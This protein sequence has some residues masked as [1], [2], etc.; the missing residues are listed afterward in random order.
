MA[1]NRAHLVA[2]R[3]GSR[4][5][6]TTLVRRLE[7]IAE[8]EDMD[9]VHKL[10]ELETKHQALRERYRTIEDLDQ[11][12][13]ALTQVEALEVEMTAVDVV[14]TVYQDALSLYQ[15]NINL[16][17]RAVEA[18]KLIFDQLHLLNHN[19]YK[20][21]CSQQTENNAPAFRWRNSTLAALLASVS[22]RN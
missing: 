20:S 5:Q 11:Q 8:N 9:D 12:I 14:N 17:R 19:T 15:H 2:L 7:T 1:N 4:G 10:H 18:A 3:G 16:L 13:Y 21:S 22:G 6:A